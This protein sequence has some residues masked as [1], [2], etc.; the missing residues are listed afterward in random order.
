MSDRTIPLS[1][2]EVVIKSI[3]ETSYLS[4]LSI[5]LHG[6]VFNTCKLS[7]ERIL[8]VYFFIL[9]ICER[10]EAIT[11]IGACNNVT[12]VCAFRTRC[13]DVISCAC[14]FS[15]LPETV[16]TDKESDNE[17]IT[18]VAKGQEIKS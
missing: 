10:S 2:S 17:A 11:V 15:I 13:F 3:F 14:R 12:L 4:Y 6:I 9:L 16:S 1:D 5:P 18:H 8:S 7:T